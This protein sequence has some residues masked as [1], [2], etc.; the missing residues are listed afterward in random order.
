[1]GKPKLVHV[2]GQWPTTPKAPTV[3]HAHAKAK[4]IFDH[5]ILALHG[6]NLGQ[7]LLRKQLSEL[8]MGLIQ[9]LRGWRPLCLCLLFGG[10]FGKCRLLLV[11]N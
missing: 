9:S 2:Q 10:L 4:V 8:L 7:V 1:M 6:V 3:P 5:L 11:G